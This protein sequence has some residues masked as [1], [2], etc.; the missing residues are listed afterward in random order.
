[1]PPSYLT[2][3]SICSC[4]QAS[5]SPR[6]SLLAPLT[7]S[8]S[9]AT[10]LNGHP[11]SPGGADDPL[12]RT[13]RIFGGLIRDIRRRYPYYLSDITDALSPQVLAAVIFIYFAAL[14]PAVTFG[15]LL[16]Q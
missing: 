12:Q 8:L 16:G 5:L 15:G 10:D 7:M 6:L 13:G 4:G 3:P 1:M 9:P 2:P 11:G 14:S